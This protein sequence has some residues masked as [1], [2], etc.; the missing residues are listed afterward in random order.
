[1][2]QAV[3]TLGEYEDRILTIVKG[4]YGFK[5]K[6][7]A[8]NFVISQFDDMVLESKLRPEFVKHIKNVQKEKGIK[9]NSL[10]DFRK[11]IERS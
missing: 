6:S 10:K 3:I 7:D 8:V 9:Y 11:K 2:T 5:N 4:K 1:M